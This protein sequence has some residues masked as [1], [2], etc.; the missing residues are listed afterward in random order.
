[1]STTSAAS[2]ATSVPEEMAMPTS[3]WASAGESLTPSPT[4]ATLCPDS[5]SCFTFFTYSKR[6]SMVPLCHSCLAYLVRRK[7]LSK[8]L[9]D[10]HLLGDGCG[11]LLV[12]TGEQDDIEA[13][14]FEGIDCQGCLRFYGVSNSHHAYQLSWRREELQCK[15]NEKEEKEANNWHKGRKRALVQYSPILI[16]VCNGEVLNIE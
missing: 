4:I 7:D 13:T 10:A 3:A 5:W 14:L 8:H 12:V 16:D 1:M 11:S 2:T 6:K 15:R 9:G